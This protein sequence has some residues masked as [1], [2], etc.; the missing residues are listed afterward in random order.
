MGFGVVGEGG[1]GGR[2]VSDFFPRNKKPR[3]GGVPV[4]DW[5]GPTPGNCKLYKYGC[6]TVFI[7]PGNAKTLRIFHEWKEV[8]PVRRLPVHVTPSC[9]ARTGRDVLQRASLSK[10][11]SAPETMALESPVTN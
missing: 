5:G 8:F 1:E 7:V 2:T 9:S 10:L 4:A 3:A 11:A 6:L